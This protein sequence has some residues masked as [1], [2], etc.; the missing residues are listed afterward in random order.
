[1]KVEDVMT[2]N[3]KKLKQE[4]TIKKALEMFEKYKVGGFPVVD[5]KDNVVGMVSESDVLKIIDVYSKVVD[6]KSNLLPLI[7]G[8]IKKTKHFEDVKKGFQKMDD[9]Q[10]LEIMKGDVVTIEKD[11]DIYT[12]AR[13]M[14]KK[15]VHRL[16]I[17]EGNKLVGIISKAD[18]V[19]ALAEE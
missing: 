18:I 9:L 11:K 1:M 4:D 19:E 7:F 6:S 3:V 5:K 16:P 8:I 17:V 10:V 2:K 14:N 12:A 15:D 13:L